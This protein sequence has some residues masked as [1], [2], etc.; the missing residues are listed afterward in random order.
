[1]LWSEA[2]GVTP[3]SSLR[4]SDGHQRAHS[5]QLGTGPPPARGPGDCAPADRCPSSE[6]HPR[7]PRVRGVIPAPNEAAQAETCSPDHPRSLRSPA[8]EV[9]GGRREV[10]CRAAIPLVRLEVPRR[11]PS[12]RMRMVVDP[13][14]VGMEPALRRDPSSFAE[15]AR[16]AAQ[17]QRWTGT[18]LV[19]YA[20][21][22]LKSSSA[23]SESNVAY[24]NPSTRPTS[25]HDDRSRRRRNMGTATQ[26][27]CGSSTV[28]PR[29]LSD[30]P[31]VER[32]RIACISCHPVR[33][34]K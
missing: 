31:Q 32:P 28:S 29:G 21:E 6:D 11:K 8:V 5:P 9:E 23:E 20:T 14:E 27:R 26:P 24:R 22:F 19:K 2:R 1:M 18:N 10:A 15:W 12:S 30:L 25:R 7:E 3:P 13:I 34:H 17:L 33:A 4:A 16:A